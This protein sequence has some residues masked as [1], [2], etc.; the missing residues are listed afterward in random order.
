MAGGPEEPG[1]SRRPYCIAYKRSAKRDVVRLDAAVRRR[2]RAAIEEWL[3]VDPRCGERPT[4]LQE[5]MTGR[6]LWSLRVGDYRVVYVFS[7]TEVW[8]PVVR[9]GHRG[10]VYQDL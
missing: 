7:D 1:G 4:G 9:V 8:L 5:A 10:R 6:P 2:I 3:A